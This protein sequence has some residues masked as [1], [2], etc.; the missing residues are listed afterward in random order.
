MTVFV[1]FP[2]PLV[3]FYLD[4]AGGKKIFQPSAF[5]SL[6]EERAVCAVVSGLLLQSGGEIFR[7]RWE[8]RGK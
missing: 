1:P 8:I 7:R 6:R 5:G 4:L 3:F 2:A